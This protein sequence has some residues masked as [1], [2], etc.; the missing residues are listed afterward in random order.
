MCMLGRNGPH[1]GPPVAVSIDKSI[2]VG[3]V[4][5]SVWNNAI[6]GPA[7]VIVFFVISGICIHYPQTR[8]GNTITSLPSYFARRYIRI[9]VPMAPAILLGML[10]GVHLDLF[11][12]TILWSLLAELIYYSVY[13]LLLTLRR[14]MTNWTVPFGGAFLLALIVASTNASA[15]EYPSY[16]SGLNWLLGLPCWLLGCEIAER[17]DGL[18]GA[19]NSTIWIWRFSVWFLAI[20]CSVL[21]FHSPVGYPWTLNVFGV[22][23]AAWVLHEVRYFKATPPRPILEQA[24]QWSYSLYLTHNLANAVFGKIKMPNLG[25]FLNWGTK[26]SFVLLFAFLFALVFEFPGHSLAR[27]L[28]VWA[29]R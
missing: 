4:I 29:K 27:K 12:K 20:A 17:I 19:G 9:L 18:A 28:S 22:F 15:A 26:M 24:G 1:R 13:P 25:F 5:N 10:V 23:V 3:W 14:R 6:S 7:A 21:R 11:T 8:T 16:G 2:V